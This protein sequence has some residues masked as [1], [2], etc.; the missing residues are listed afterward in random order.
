V[1]EEECDTKLLTEREQQSGYYFK[2]NDGALLRSDKETTMRTINMGIASRVLSPNEG[3]ELVDMNPYEGGDS[4]ENPA[5]TPGNGTNQRGG[6]PDTEPARQPARNNATLVH[7]EHMIGVEAKRAMQAAASSKNFCVWIEEFYGK[8]ATKLA[9]DIERLGGDRE[10]AQ[11][12]CQESIAQ[13]LDC[14][15]RAKPETLEQVVRD[16]VNQWPTRAAALANEME[17][18]NV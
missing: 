6:E 5:I 11:R 3:R 10:L 4:Y 14:A 17:L 9:D 7:V 16:C 1:W 18:R 2:F 13:L 12:H 15:D 8:W